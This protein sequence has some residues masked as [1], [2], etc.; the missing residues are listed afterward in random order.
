MEKGHSDKD[1]ASRSADEE[2]SKPADD[3]GNQLLGYRWP[4]TQL[5]R[6]DMRNLKLASLQVRRPITQLVKEAVQAYF[7]VLSRE[8]AIRAVVEKI[9]DFE[10]E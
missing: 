2:S 9:E 8:V 7:Q 5:T 4:A 1:E 3:W 10:G 6:Q